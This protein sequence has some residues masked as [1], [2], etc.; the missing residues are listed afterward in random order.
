MSQPSYQI[1]PHQPESSNYG[2]LPKTK[3]TIPTNA[4]PLNDFMQV[5]E[6][7]SGLSAVFESILN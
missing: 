6:F 4:V 1:P 2:I 5:E 7:L 3:I